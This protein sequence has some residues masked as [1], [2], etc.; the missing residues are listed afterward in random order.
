MSCGE[1]RDF[2]YARYTTSYCIMPLQTAAES[3]WRCSME[4]VDEASLKALDMPP[5][6]ASDSRHSIG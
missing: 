1:M 3:C 6:V 2:Q 5:P 4:K